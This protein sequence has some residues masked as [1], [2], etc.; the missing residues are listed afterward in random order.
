M[1][2]SDL[3]LLLD[4]DESKIEQWICLEDEIAK[5]CQDSERKQK[6]REALENAKEDVSLLFR[7]PD[8]G[9]R[10]DQDNAKQHLEHFCQKVALGEFIDHRPEFITEVIGDGLGCHIKAEVRLPTCLPAQL[11]KFSSASAWVSETNAMKDAA[12]QAL[13]A[14]YHA[15]LI[16]QHL[17]P[18]ESAGTRGVET[19]SAMVC[20]EPIHQPWRDVAMA[21]ENEQ[22]QWAYR[23]CL[24]GPIPS[25]FDEYSLTLPVCLWP[26]PPVSVYIDHETAYQVYFSAPEAISA[27][28]S[29]ATADET[30]VLL[31]LHFIH[32]W[33]FKKASHVIKISSDDS[34]AMSGLGG[35]LF[36]PSCIHASSRQYLIRDSSLS[37]GIYVETLQSKPPLEMVRHP[38][39]NYKEAPEEPYVHLSRWTRRIDFLHRPQDTKA[40]TP[41]T[42]PYDCVVPISWARTDTIPIMHARFGMLIPSIIHHIE[43]LLVAKELSETLLRPLHISDLTLLVEAITCPSANKSISYDRLE[44]IGDSILKYC[45][46]VQAAATCTSILAATVFF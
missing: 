3:I 7:V 32:R 22:T 46:S 25:L 34:L 11:R 5:L 12:F 23:I 14:L 44:F 42:K 16:N 28:E 45:A 24:Q 38:F 40:Q 10:L 15:G 36:S 39:E 6:E 9:A 35:C 8:T 21:W 26:V 33:D 43:T 4:T 31:A 29:A 41:S 2:K 19:R 30:S 17:L 18:Y 1:Q 37:P 13:V 20:V 27:A